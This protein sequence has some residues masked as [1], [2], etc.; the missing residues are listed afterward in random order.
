MILT[1]SDVLQLPP[2]RPCMLSRAKPVTL[3]EAERDHILNA[4]TQ[5]L[6]GQRQVW[7]RRT[8]GREKN[9]IDVQNE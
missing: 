5:Q 2:L 3:A 4:P 7:R 8:F 6:G 1:N 9:D